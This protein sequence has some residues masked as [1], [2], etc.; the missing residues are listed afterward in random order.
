[1]NIFSSKPGQNSKFRLESIPEIRDYINKCYSSSE[2]Y[3]DRGY[4]PE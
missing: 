2:G 4:Q 1:M 3:V